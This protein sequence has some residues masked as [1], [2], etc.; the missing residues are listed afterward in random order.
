[1]PTILIE[2]NTPHRQKI[3]DL[4]TNEP[5]FN[6][7]TVTVTP[8]QAGFSGAYVYKIAADKVYVLKILDG[9]ITKERR[10]AEI[11]YYSKAAENG[12]APPLIYTNDELFIMKYIEGAHLLPSDINNDETLQKMA[13]TLR[14]LHLSQLDKNYKLYDPA[15]RITDTVTTIRNSNLNL[16]NEIYVIFNLLFDLNRYFNNHLQKSFVHFDLNFGNILFS[17]EYLNYIDFE[18]SGYGNIFLDMGIFAAYLDLTP[19]RISKFLDYYFPN[20]DNKKFCAQV[21]LAK[22]FGLARMLNIAIR[23]SNMLSE[24]EY[25]DLLKNYLLTD[26][27]TTYGGMLVKFLKNEF[28][29]DSRKK[30]IVFALVCINSIHNA[31]RD[32]HYIQSRELLDFKNYMV[33]LMAN[34]AL[35]QSYMEKSNVIAS[36]K[37]L[38]LLKGRI[39]SSNKDDLEP[40]DQQI[41][42]NEIVQDNQL[43]SKQNT[44]GISIR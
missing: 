17:G 31:I 28:V 9:K 37:T 44:S 36:P 35:N 2:D 22:I 12:I 41:S 10:A 32:P 40:T 39:T 1:M 15:I 3:I 21:Y 5:I 20:Q 24:K 18:V 16:P 43:P 23:E 30:F 34:Y 8:M 6:C 13:L 25:V 29:F 19:E 11:Y 42:P 14:R 26:T 27:K 38:L 7:E 33:N 4:F